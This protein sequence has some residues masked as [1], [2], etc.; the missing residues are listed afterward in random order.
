MRDDEFIYDYIEYEEKLIPHEKI[1]IERLAVVPKL[2]YNYE[3]L[4]QKCLQYSGISAFSVSWPYCTCT[5][6]GNYLL[7]VNAFDKEFIQRIQLADES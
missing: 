6:Y 7:L 2:V 5:G 3:G 1:L 4:N